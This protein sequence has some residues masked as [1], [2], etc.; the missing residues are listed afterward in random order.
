MTEFF[1][2]GFRLETES[3]KALNDAYYETNSTLK[4]LKC[5]TAKLTVTMALTSLYADYADYII[6][7][8]NQF[9]TNYSYFFERII[10]TLNDY[11]DYCNLVLN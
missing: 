1:K 5:Q 9:A 4:R 6:R 3:F 2:N 7:Y 8:K 11:L 10:D